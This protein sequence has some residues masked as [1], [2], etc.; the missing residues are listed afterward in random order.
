M[1]S[2]DIKKSRRTPYGVPSCSSF[3]GSS[4]FAI[5]TAASSSA[6]SRG[7]NWRIAATRLVFTTMSPRGASTE[8]LP[9]FVPPK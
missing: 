6:S 2:G 8:T 7:T 5:A 9:Q 4:P 3:A 1:P